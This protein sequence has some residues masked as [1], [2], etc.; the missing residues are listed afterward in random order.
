M[1][2]A[3]APTAEEPDTLSK[4]ATTM[5]PL[6][7]ATAARNSRPQGTSTAEATQGIT[8]AVAAAALAEDLEVVVV[9]AV[10]VVMPVV[11]Q[12]G[13][14]AVALVLGVEVYSCATRRGSSGPIAVLGIQHPTL[15]AV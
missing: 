2:E 11:A 9:V 7:G 5:S 4:S 10:V 8:R 12:G 3:H 1:K 13:I 15:V 14:W 6:A